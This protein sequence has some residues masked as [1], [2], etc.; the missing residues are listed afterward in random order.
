LWSSTGIESKV[1]GSNSRAKPRRDG[2]GSIDDKQ[3]EGK[4]Q[5]R[6]GFARD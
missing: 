1:T 3:L 5:E 4:I 2:D 6:Y